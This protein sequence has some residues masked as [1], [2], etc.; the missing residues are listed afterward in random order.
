[1]DALTH[2]PAGI[3][4]VAENQEGQDAFEY[5]LVIGGVSVAVIIAMAT[6]IGSALA[7]KVV[8]GTCTAIAT[9]PN[10]TSVTC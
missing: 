2:L 10:M 8:T 6:P 1:M 3:R 9:I 4:Q 5:L 7:G